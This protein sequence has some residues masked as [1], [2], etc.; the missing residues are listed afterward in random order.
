M[1]EYLLS[2]KNYEELLLTDTNTSTDFIPKYISGINYHEFTR[3]LVS[4]N[5][6]YTTEESSLYKLLEDKEIDIDDAAENGHLEVV[7]YLY[8]Q[9]IEATEYGIDYAVRYGHL[10]VVK[11][12]YSKKLEPTRDGIDDAAENGRI[13]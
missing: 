12:L 2:T 9:G 6:E 5:I 1:T 11:Y 13:V 10:E 8:K 4:E 3:Y 7:K